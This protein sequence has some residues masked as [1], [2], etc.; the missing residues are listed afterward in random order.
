MPVIDAVIPAR[1]E[2]DTIGG[3][4]DAVRACSFVREVIVVDDGSS[5]TTA[6]LALAAGAKVVRP[7]G[8]LGGSKAH[9]MRAGV[10]ASDADS[11]LFC[12]GDLLGLTA[13]HLDGICRPHVD[14]EAVMSLGTFDYGLFNP[15]VLRMPPT[16]G[17]R[18]VPRWV[19]EAIPTDRLDG[20]TIEVMINAVVCECRLPISAAVMAGVSHRTKREK[21]GRVEGYR[22]T[23]QM[24]W[25]LVG[26]LRTV[27]WRTY[28]FFLCDVAIQ[29]KLG[30]LPPA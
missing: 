25:Q 26:L 6:E 22:R 9:A 8:P 7:A 27:R 2:A 24:F 18:I 1:N 23:W 20:Y 11:I 4:V 19:F 30:A 3:V 13:V 17:E 15:L 16:T 29:P 10:A 14:G 21:F 5:D 28:W 12:D